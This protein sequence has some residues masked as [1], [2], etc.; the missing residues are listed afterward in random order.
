MACSET[1]VR[2]YTRRYGTYCTGGRT[3]TCEDYSRIHN[4]G[5]KGCQHSSTEGYWL[6]VKSCCDTTPGVCMSPSSEW[7]QIKSKVPT[8]SENDVL[9]FEV[10]PER[11]DDSEYLGV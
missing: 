10:K 9:K 11:D 8:N 1:C 4:G 3:P 5:P 2:A 6:K 7:M